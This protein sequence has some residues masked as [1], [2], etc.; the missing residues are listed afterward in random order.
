MDLTTAIF[1][2]TPLTPQEEE[3]I[4]DELKMALKKMSK[5]DITTKLKVKNLLDNQIFEWKQSLKF[6]GLSFF[7]FYLNKPQNVNF[8]F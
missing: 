6:K 8:L 2:L 7:Y 1:G 4:P 3:L 5:K